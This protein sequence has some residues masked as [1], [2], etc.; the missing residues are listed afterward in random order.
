MCFKKKTPPKQP[1]PSI[2]FG[3]PYS[4]SM[5]IPNGLILFFFSFSPLLLKRKRTSIIAEIKT[6]NETKTN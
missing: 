1:H 3:V 2:S 4:S 5:L 6:T